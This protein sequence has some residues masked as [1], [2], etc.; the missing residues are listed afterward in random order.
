MKDKKT[1]G[2]FIAGALLLMIAV[3]NYF[4]LT[5]SQPVRNEDASSEQTGISSI[6]GKTMPDNHDQLV[7][8]QQLM[9]YLK[10]N[11]TDTDHWIQLGNMLFDAGNFAEAIEP[12]RTALQQRSE[13]NDVRTDYAVCLFN[14]NR[15]DEAITELNV[16]IKNN[17][18]H[19][20]ALYNLGVIH[21]HNGRNDQARIFWNRAIQAAPN[22]DIAPK[23]RQAL[24][25]L[26]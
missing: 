15:S 25:N 14:T 4:Q 2:F 26:K 21:S 13:N 7:Q 10:S 6:E 24:T 11:P 20:T 22:S 9:E 19:A 18:D 5:A 17:P 16:V 23:A 3:Y 12:Y 1:L 8:V